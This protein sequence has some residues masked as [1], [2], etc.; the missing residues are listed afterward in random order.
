MLTFFFF[1]FFSC[2]LSSFLNIVYF[3][4]ADVGKYVGLGLAEGPGQTVWVCEERGEVSRGEVSGGEGEKRQVSESRNETRPQ[5]I[6]N[7]ACRY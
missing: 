1:D 4:L 5:L 6:I 3:R 2:D 7:Y